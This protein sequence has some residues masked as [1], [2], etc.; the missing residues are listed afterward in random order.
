MSC[1][2]R[3]V[4]EHV[5]GYL[6]DSLP[7]SLKQQCDEA[8]AECAECR[9]M[10]EQCRMFQQFGHQWQDQKVPHWHRTRFA[11]QPPRQASG[12]WLGWSALATSCLAILMVLFNLE[13]S[14]QDGMTISFG[15]AANERRMETLLSQRMVEFRQQ[16]SV[17]MDQQ[18]SEFLDEQNNANQVLLADWLRQSRRERRD[19]LDFVMTVWQS[20]RL[21][22]Q[23]QI[24]QQFDYLA[25]SQIESNE[26]IND[27]LQNVQNV[28]YPPER[29]L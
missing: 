18:F 6:E 4:T 23:R 20:Q 21:E 10:L 16:Q 14:F 11:V 22:D 19:D 28:S 3:L 27:L 17:A 13:L 7:L 9:D 15:G 26:A 8:L 2:H 24:G 29:E 1:D 12:N 25:N 5:Y